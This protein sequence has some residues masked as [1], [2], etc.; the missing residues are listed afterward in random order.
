[1]AKFEQGH[2]QDALL[3]GG[4]AV[5]VPAAS[6]LMN[7]SLY[8]WNNRLKELERM[9]NIDKSQ[10]WEIE[11]EKQFIRYKLNLFQSYELNEELFQQTLRDMEKTHRSIEKEMTGLQSYYKTSSRVKWKW[12]G[13]YLGLALILILTLVYGNNIMET[14]PSL[15]N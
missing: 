4:D 7:E 2:A 8:Q 1:M 9:D 13:L 11:F 14:N 10:R 12:I 15:F 3:Q 5:E 6:E